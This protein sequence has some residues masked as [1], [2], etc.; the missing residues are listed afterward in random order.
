MKVTVSGKTLSDLES[1]SMSTLRSIIKYIQHNL[2]EHG[3]SN[4]EHHAAIMIPELIEQIR[5]IPITKYG[6][7]KTKELMGNHGIIWNDIHLCPEQSFCLNLMAMSKG[8]TMGIHDHPNINGL[9]HILNGRVHHQSFDVL[10]REEL[11][12]KQY[13]PKVFGENETF[14]T[15]HIHE[16][17]HSF[18][19]L[20]DSIIFGILI[21]DFNAQRIQSF[22]DIESEYGD[23]VRLKKVDVPN[24]CNDINSPFDGT[25]D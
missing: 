1:N 21:P 20:E 3:M 5:S 9:N 17:M 15:S 6:S 2:Q 12:A 24:H 8:T 4:H 18:H 23:V 13:P 14:I 25:L 11:I 19:A 16:N 22:F 7:F 10:S